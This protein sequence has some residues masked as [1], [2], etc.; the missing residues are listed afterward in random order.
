MHHRH[1][2]HQDYTLAAID[3]IISRG[4]F[5]D[6]LAL[7]GMSLDDRDILEKVSHIARN[8]ATDPHA[9]RY[10]FWKLYVESHAA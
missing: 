9:Q 10:R 7:R 6:W 8:G 2:A 4:G 5:Q 3:D 1:L